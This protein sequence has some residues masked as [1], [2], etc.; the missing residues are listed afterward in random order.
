MIVV[1]PEFIRQ[2]YTTEIYDLWVQYY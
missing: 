2:V 1:Q